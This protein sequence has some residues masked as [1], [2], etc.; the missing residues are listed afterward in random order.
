MLGF[1]S[2]HNTMAFSGGCRYKPTMSAAFADHGLDALV[3]VGAADLGGAR[4]EPAG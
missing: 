4:L 1:S 3:L 2:T